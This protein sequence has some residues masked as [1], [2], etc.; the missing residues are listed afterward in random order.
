MNKL[1]IPIAFLALY[2]CAWPASAVSIYECEDDQ[3]NRTFQERCPPGTKP[4]DTRNYAVTTPSEEEAKAKLAVNLYTVPE[5]ELCNQM[6]EFLN[7]R[8]ISFTEKN[9]QDDVSLQNEL[10]EK[11]GSLRVPTLIVGEK[12]VVGYNRGAATAALIEGGY[13]ETSAAEAA[14]EGEETP[15]PGAEGA[16]TEEGAPA[17]ESRP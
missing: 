8:Q 11:A 9:V 10:K 4:V 16:A 6:R 1:H 12:A 5:C 7:V 13:L 3:G 17:G 15:G 14:T 2:L